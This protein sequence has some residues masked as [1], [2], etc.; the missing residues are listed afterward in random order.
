M[1]HAAVFAVG[2]FI[3]LGSAVYAVEKFSENFALNIDP[4]SRKQVGEKV[5][6]DIKTFFHEA[7]RAIETE[8]MEAL[9]ALYSKNYKNGE[10]TKKS[11]EKIWKRIFSQINN[12]STI[13]NMRFITITSDSDVMILRCSGILLGIPKGE[14]NL[15]TIDNWTNADHVLTKESGKWKLIGTYGSDRKRFWF[16]RPMHPLF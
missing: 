4:Y 13:H 10:H 8:N 9:M 7:E 1:K 14:R 6:S 16:G 11:A 12:M 3:F 15:I 2:L 5:W